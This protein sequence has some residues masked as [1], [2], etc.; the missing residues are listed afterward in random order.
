MLSA[1]YPEVE[2]ERIRAVGFDLDG[3]LY[4]E[5]DFVKQVYKSILSDSLRY[6]S[7]KSVNRIYE[8]VLRRW[9]EEGSSYDRIFEEAYGK[10]LGHLDVGCDSF[11]TEALRIFREYKPILQLSNRS[12]FILRR[13]Q[14]NYQIFLVSDGN[15]DL[16]KNKFRSLGLDDYFEKKNVFFT[17]EYGRDYYK[18]SVK[19]S[20]VL[21][22][23]S[24]TDNVLY[25]GN[26]ELDREYAENSGFHFLKL[27]NMVAP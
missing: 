21:S 8:F 14:Q 22:L 24:K 1:L 27:H 13:I 16:Q 19:I 5:F 3:T 23:N 25:I 4:D 11:V 20:T 15:P 10:Y 18:P 7:E 17:G 9:L 2:W 6:E 12:Q 26:R